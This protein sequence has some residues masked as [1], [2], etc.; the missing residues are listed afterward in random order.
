[1]LCARELG[2]ANIA[3]NLKV[4]RAEWI[5]R[6]ASPRSF[7]VL[8]VAHRMNDLGAGAGLGAA[9]EKPTRFAS[10]GVASGLLGQGRIGTGILFFRV[11]GPG[12]PP[13]LREADIY[14]ISHRADMGCIPS[15]T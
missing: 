5:G 7:P 15:K 14:V 3:W 1:M 12:Q 10:E 11:L 9:V 8:D 13:R 6:L 2:D 4:A